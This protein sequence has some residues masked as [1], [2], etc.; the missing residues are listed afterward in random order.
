VASSVNAYPAFRLGESEDE[1]V[2]K[3][4]TLRQG[5][6]NAASQSTFAL[7]ANSFSTPINDALITAYSFIG[8]APV[9]TAAAS[10]WP[11]TFVITQSTGVA[12]VCHVS[13]TATNRVFKY[14]ILG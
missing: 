8:I 1:R 10:A 6:V 5:K 14:T 12:T 3:L 11:S 2:R 7:A 4:N 13:S 9:T